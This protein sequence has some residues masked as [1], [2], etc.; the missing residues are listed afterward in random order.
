MGEYE[1]RQTYKRYKEV[2]DKSMG[3]LSDE[4]LRQFIPKAAD[5]LDV[6]RSHLGEL[7]VSLPNG[8]SHIHV[9]IR[10]G[11]A[12]WYLTHYYRHHQ[13]GTPPEGSVRRAIREFEDRAGGAS[14]IRCEYR[15]HAADASYNG[16]HDDPY[17]FYL[18]LSIVSAVTRS[19]WS[20]G[21]SS[22][23]APR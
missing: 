15:L 16:V 19:R 22:V 2:D 6:F 1:Y 21:C 4:E 5:Q 18:H 14:V 10:S 3:I 9:P 17:A 20:P 8:R 13:A 12:R 7:F 11:L 23:R